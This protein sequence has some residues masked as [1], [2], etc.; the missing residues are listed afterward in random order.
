MSVGSIGNSSATATASG[1]KPGSIDDP[2]QDFLSY[3]TMTPGERMENAWLRQHN[4]TRAQF[5]ALSPEEKEK[6][7]EQMRQDIERQLK[8][9]AEKDLMDKL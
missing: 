9:K 2:T 6:V 8:Q 1:K 5:E 4:M 3:M 7:R